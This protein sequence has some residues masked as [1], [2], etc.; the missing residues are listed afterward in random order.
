MR[1]KEN[2]YKEKRIYGCCASKEKNIDSAWEIVGESEHDDVHHHTITTTFNQRRKTWSRPSVP[3]STSATWW[4]TTSTLLTGECSFTCS[5]TPTL[6]RC[7]TSSV[8]LKKKDHW[9]EERV[10]SSRTGLWK[11]SDGREDGGYKGNTRTF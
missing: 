4:I 3:A 11:L 8:F 6:D 10:A 7:S 9:C 1:V 2:E 5:F